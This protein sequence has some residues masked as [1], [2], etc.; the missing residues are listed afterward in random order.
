MKQLSIFLF[1]HVFAVSISSGQVKKLIATDL[2]KQNVRHDFAIGFGNF[3]GEPS[4][5]YVY[6]LKGFPN[7]RVGT[8]F[9]VAG[10]YR[11]NSASFGL[12]AV[13]P[14]FSL[15]DIGWT[16]QVNFLQNR[17]FSLG[18]EAVVGA[19]IATLS[20]NAEK[21]TRQVFFSTG[22]GIGYVQEVEE[23][24]VVERSTFFLFKPSLNASVR[25]FE[26]LRLQA[27]GNYR[28][29]AGRSKFGSRSEMDGWMFDA[30]VA[31]V[32]PCPEK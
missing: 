12:Q 15:T 32:I 21:E 7:E 8:G 19:A 3:I 9:H 23:P 20:D 27:R 17:R 11:K 2:L 4:R 5:F 6:N 28:F 30:G 10:I 22:E 31:L 16:N 24:K 1:L 13:E 26:Y 29:L 18:M 25:L 14:L